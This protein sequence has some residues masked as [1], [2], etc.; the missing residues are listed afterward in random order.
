MSYTKLTS[1][2][3]V[4]VVASDIDGNAFTLDSGY[5][6]VTKELDDS[7]QE[8][9]VTVTTFFDDKLNEIGEKN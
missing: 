3:T 6:L 8:T 5:L 4:T 7:A 2:N 1:T 9:G